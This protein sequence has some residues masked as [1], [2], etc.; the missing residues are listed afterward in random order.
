MGEPVPVLPDRF[1]ALRADGLPIVE[2]NPVRAAMVDAP[3]RYPWS[4]AR[5]NPGLRPATFLSA[6]DVHLALGADALERAR[7]YGEWL[8]SG[9]ADEDLEAIRSHI[10]QQHALGNPRSQA[11]VAKA[12]NRPVAVRSRGRPRK[13]PP[14]G[15]PQAPSSASDSNGQLLRPL[16]PIAALARGSWRSM[17]AWRRGNRFRRDVRASCMA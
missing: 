2:L 4:S 5:E 17:R 10:R 6:H 13:H 14:D 9:M 8:R 7:A 12:L 16:W 11:M 15:A 3:E 1:G